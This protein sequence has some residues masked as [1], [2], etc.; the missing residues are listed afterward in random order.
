MFQGM[1][2]FSL[3]YCFF[4]AAGSALLRFILTERKKK[5][6]WSIGPFLKEY[7]HC[8]TQ[9]AF[10]GCFWILTNYYIIQFLGSTCSAQAILYLKPDVW[11]QILPNSD[12]CIWI[13]WILSVHC[14]TTAKGQKRLQCMTDQTSH[15][16]VLIGK[17]WWKCREE[18]GWNV[19]C[20]I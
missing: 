18:R 9:T 3:K 1:P 12:V 7:I 5:Y 15:Q 20:E 13:T 2:Y 11:I 17:V 8:S 6:L 14:Q 19:L 10:L 4:T 16:T